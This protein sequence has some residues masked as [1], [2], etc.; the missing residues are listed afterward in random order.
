MSEKVL[1]L[2]KELT[3]TDLTLDQL[4]ILK[5]IQDEILN[6]KTTENV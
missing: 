5:M 6:S 4:E 1:F 2:F 3:N